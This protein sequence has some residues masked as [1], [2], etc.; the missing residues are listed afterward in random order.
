[1]NRTI[2]QVLRAHAAQSE[3]EWDKTL[4]LCEFAMNNSVHKGLG[5]T[6]FF[7]NYGRTPITPVML[8]LV[9]LDKIAC[10][11]AL[12]EAE[13]KDEAF[14]QAMQNLVVARD[15]YKS[16]AD[17]H[18]KDAVFEKDQLVLL[19]TANLNRHRQNR[20]LYPKWVGPFRVLEAVNDAAYKL[21]LPDC[22]NIHD[23]F[24]VS[25][26]RKYNSSRGTA[27]QPKPLVIDGELEFEVE[28]ILDHRDRIV[29]SGRKGKPGKGAPLSKREYYVKWLGYGVEHC[30]W[31]KEP[32][33]S[34][35]TE[36]LQEY[37]DLHAKL[38][39]GQKPRQLVKRRAGQMVKAPKK[40][41]NQA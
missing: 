1:M 10:A 36:T 20:K 35:C 41:R 5:K 30:T 12:A 6:P 14:S 25:L 3:Q 27:L 38:A 21:E 37:W 32:N 8:K 19:S 33:L 16:Y 7:L 18:R 34:N 4:K 31:E 23:V 13:T 26:L 24:H 39:A 29:R 15:R 11:T 2:E 28:K 40:A 22:M 17:S 9:Q